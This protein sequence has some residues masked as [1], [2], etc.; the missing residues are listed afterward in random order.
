[1]IFSLLAAGCGAAGRHDPPRRPAA[2]ASS[3]GLS[4]YPAVWGVSRVAA[5]QAVSRAV[6]AANPIMKSP[7]YAPAE[8]EYGVQVVCKRPSA[9]RY[10]CSWRAVNTYSVLGG[11]ARV[12]FAQARA[13]VKLRQTSCGRHVGP[14]KDSPLT[15][16]AVI[17]YDE[18]PKSNR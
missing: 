18:G 13:R 4:R 14:G 3:H 10:R 7:S 11:Y 6:T 15:R 2:T 5:V 9:G 17:G 8:S 16:C 12:H 1:M